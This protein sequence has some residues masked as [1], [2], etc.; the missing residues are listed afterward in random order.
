MLR[1]LIDKEFESFIES[2][3]IENGFENLIT[4]PYIRY[5]DTKDSKFLQLKEIICSEHH[6]PTDFLKDAVSVLSYFLP[7]TTVSAGTAE[8]GSD[9]YIVYNKVY[10]LTKQMIPKINL[11]L[12]NYINKLGYKAV[13]PYDTAPISKECMISRWSEKHIGAIAG[14]G[15]FGINGQL[16]SDYGCAGRIS[17]LVTTL[18]I[19]AD[20]SIDEERC[21]YKKNGGCGLC[22]KSCVSGA[23]TKNGF[24]KYKCMK[25]NEE[26]AKSGLGE[27]NKCAFCSRGVPCA[28]KVP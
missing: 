18:P 5:A 27:K 28:Y 1:K 9:K 11:H 15:T 8:E 21:I 25:Y 24:D 10:A 16:I 4:K 2:Y 14:L 17:T 13:S 20:K 7:L 19:E 23:L 22:I 26:L 6:L 3:I 12:I